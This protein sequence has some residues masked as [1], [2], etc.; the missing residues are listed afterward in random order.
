MMQTDRTDNAIV[1]LGL[2]DF[3]KLCWKN[4]I[5]TR[6]FRTAAFSLRAFVGFIR[7]IFCVG[8]FRV[9]K[10]AL[11]GN[12][13]RAPLELCT[14]FYAFSYGPKGGQYYT[15]LAKEILSCPVPSLEKTRFYSLFQNSGIHSYTDLM[16]CHSQSL[17]TRLPDIPFGSFPWGH[18]DKNII[19]DPKKFRIDKTSPSYIRWTGRGPLKEILRKAFT[20]IYDLCKSITMLGYRYDLF[21]FYFPK[22][23]ILVAA[24]GEKRFVLE[25]GSH[26]LA[27]LSALGHENA[28]LLLDPKRFPG[29]FEKD[30]D[31]WFYVSSGL[32]GREE[33]LC[34][35]NLYFNLNGRERIKTIMH[36]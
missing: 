35:F 15:D 7:A 19:M 1:R 17:K 18:F 10:C 14:D 12:I 23:S 34:F 3:I 4:F 32:I 36:D 9:L 25:D 22:A 2:R 26:R 29:I 13:I 30:V 16:T 28:I 6:N 11:K 31:T 8:F 20:D 33:A 21:D 27:V 24:S 5:I